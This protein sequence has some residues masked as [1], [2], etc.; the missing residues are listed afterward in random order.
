ASSISV[1]RSEVPPDPY[2]GR[3]ELRSA[4]TRTTD[5]SALRT[6]RGGPAGDDAPFPQLDDVIGS[7]LDLRRRMRDVHGGNRVRGTQPIEIRQ[8]L[9]AVR[10]IDGRQ[11]LVE[12][13][14]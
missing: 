1:G 4:P 12:K 14:Q 9:R 11:R 3:T 2:V 8:D 5:R 13:Q 7:A 6:V 10:L